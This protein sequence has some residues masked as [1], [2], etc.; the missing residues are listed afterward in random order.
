MPNYVLRSS[1]MYFYKLRPDTVIIGELFVGFYNEF[2][3]ILVS[4][5]KR[6]KNAFLSCLRSIEFGLL[7]KIITAT[8]TCEM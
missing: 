4:F 2:L 3:I 7:I 8:L 6:E 5:A 1:Y